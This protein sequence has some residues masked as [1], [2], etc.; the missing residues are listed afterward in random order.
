[1][2]SS[3]EVESFKK[4]IMMWQARLTVDQPFYYMFPTL[5]QHIE[6]NGT[7]EEHLKKIKCD[8]QLH[9]HSLWASFEQYFPEENLQDIRDKNW[10]KNRFAFERPE[11]VAWL[12]LSP[13]QEMSFFISQVIHH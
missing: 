4:S 2:Y 12:N 7:S 13:N 1:M 11:A 3:E 5:S 9:L 6:E 8:I 10:V